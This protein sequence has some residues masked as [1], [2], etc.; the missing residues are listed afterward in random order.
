MIPRSSSAGSDRLGI[1]LPGGFAPVAR[2]AMAA[3]LID[4]PDARQ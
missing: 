3:A 4:A 1:A 2:A